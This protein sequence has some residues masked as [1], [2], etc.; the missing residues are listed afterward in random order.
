[1]FGVDFIISLLFYFLL[2][3]FF[4][5]VKH[6]VIVSEWFTPREPLL[7]FTYKYNNQ[8]H[9][10]ELYQRGDVEYERICQIAERSK[11]IN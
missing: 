3:E 4:H 6:F 11:C 5:L 10:A 2:I 9:T 1:M 8:G 7:P